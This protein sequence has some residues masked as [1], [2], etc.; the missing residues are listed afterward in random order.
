MKDMS[1]VSSPPFKK[2]KKKGKSD[3]HYQVKRMKRG[4]KCINDSQLFTLFIQIKSKI[5]SITGTV[6][7][8]H[9]PNFP[10]Q[11]RE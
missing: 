11:V 6:R 2:K 7:L 1:L 4:L 10:E 3:Q 5:V 8:I 9:T